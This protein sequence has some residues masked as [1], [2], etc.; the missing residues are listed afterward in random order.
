MGRGKLGFLEAQAFGGAQSTVVI[1][2]LVKPQKRKHYLLGSDKGGKIPRTKNLVVVVLHN[3][4]VV[5]RE[6]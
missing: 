2:K 6:I 1:D 3:T 4:L 5:H